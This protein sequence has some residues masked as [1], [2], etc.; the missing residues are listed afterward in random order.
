[1][2]IEDT[3]VRKHSVVVEGHRTSVSMEDAFWKGLK[4]I[5]QARH[6]S[7]NQLITEI[8]RQREASLSSAIK[9]YVFE[10][11]VNRSKLKT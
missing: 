8:D 5:A 9:V 4:A 10:N 1:M 11:A 3:R 6:R 2:P 7:I